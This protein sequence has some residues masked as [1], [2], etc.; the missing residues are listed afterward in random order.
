M[1]IGIVGSGPAGLTAAIQIK[2]KYMDSE[3]SIFE[4]M[5]KVGKKLL[6]SGNGKGNVSNA[7]MSVDYYNTNLVKDIIKMDVVG[8]LNSCGILTKQDKE[9]RIYPYNEQ[10]QMVVECL[11]LE[12]YELGIK[13]IPEKVV[14]IGVNYLSTFFNNYYFDKIIIASGGKSQEFL[15]SDGSMFR[16]IQGLGHTVTELKPALCPIKTKEDFSDIQGLRCKVSARAYNG[17][18][19]YEDKGE[20]LFKEDG[21]SGI[22]VF[23]ISSIFARSSFGY[24]TFDFFPDMSE[25]ELVDVIKSLKQD[26]YIDLALMGIINR[27][28][29]NHILGDTRG[30]FL[31]D[32]DPSILA[33]KLKNYKI[34]CIK[35]Y[36]FVQSQVT[37][38]GVPL[39]ELKDNLESKLVPNIYFI[40]EVLNVDGLSGGYNIHF[41]ISS[42]LWLSSKL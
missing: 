40:G 23:Q 12:I 18:D 14:G 1:K 15:G 20:L 27:K 7:N 2:R 36:D 34:E 21:I 38:G 9:G 13:I 5:P 24:V 26:R 41:A 17:E 6:A 42:A 3:V 25:D 35:N 37:V 28:L 16:A 31:K 10:A 4:Y 29:L 39:E 11:K 19:F 30:K 32:F 22:I 8:F 33:Y